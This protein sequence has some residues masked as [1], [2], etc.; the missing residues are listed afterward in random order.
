MAIRDMKKDN[1]F[2]ILQVTKAWLRSDKHLG[3]AVS[4]MK[5]RQ[6]VLCIPA[7]WYGRINS[8]KP[9]AS[10]TRN[11]AIMDECHK[12]G[13]AGSRERVDQCVCAARAVEVHILVCLRSSCNHVT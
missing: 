2:K 6:S 12:P 4:F 1:I 10:G 13:N 5:L 9:P 8:T 7:Y 11:F 3:A